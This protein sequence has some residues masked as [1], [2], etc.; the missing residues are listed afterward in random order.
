MKQ[1]RYYGQELKATVEN[2]RLVIAIGVQ[3][4]AH[5]SAYA[6]WAN[7]FDEAAD[8]Y[9]RTFAIDDAPQ[10]AQD[11]VLAML[12]EEEDGSTPLTVFLD[13]MAQAAIEDGSLGLHEDEQHIKHGTFAPCET[14]S[15]PAEGR[16]HERYVQFH[17]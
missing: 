16:S 5:A 6:D 17:H 3:T 14:W 8:D 7:P 15:V 13:K 2:G 11:V 4:L 1:G 10:F 9:I 12:A